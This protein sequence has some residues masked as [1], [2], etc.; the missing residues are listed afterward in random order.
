MQLVLSSWLM[1][2]WGRYHVDSYPS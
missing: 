2:L 1:S